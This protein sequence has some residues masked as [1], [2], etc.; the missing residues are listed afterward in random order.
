MLPFHNRH[1]LGIY[2]ARFITVVLIIGFM[3]STVSVTMTGTLIL[4][5]DQGKLENV[6]RNLKNFSQFK[7]SK[8]ASNKM[9]AMITA[10]Q[11]AS[12]IIYTK[13]T[14]ENTHNE[15]IGVVFKL[16]FICTDSARIPG[17]DHG[18]ALS[19]PDWINTYRSIDI[20]PTPPPPIFLS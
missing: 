2:F 6:I 8:E 5:N 13:Q 20:S 11:S 3:S 7:S 9:R 17:A 16:P 10:L 14:S 18:S 4:N 1:D 15:I 19:E 12:G